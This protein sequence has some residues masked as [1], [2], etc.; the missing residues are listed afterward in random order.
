MKNDITRNNLFFNFVKQLY[1][2]DDREIPLVVEQ[3][4]YIEVLEILVPSVMEHQICG[5]YLAVGH[6][7]HVGAL[8]LSGS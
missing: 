8:L 2:T 3:V 4:V 1:E 6:G 5:H 7:S